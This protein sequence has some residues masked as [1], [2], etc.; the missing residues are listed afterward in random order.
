M[1]DH[2][3]RH[4]IDAQDCLAARQHLHAFVDGELDGVEQRM[5]ARE[6]VGHHLQRCVRCARLE[7][8]LRQLRLTLAAVAARSAQGPEERMTPAFRARMTALLAG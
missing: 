4:G 8:Q 5:M 7:R 1:H 2:P 3:H 6:A